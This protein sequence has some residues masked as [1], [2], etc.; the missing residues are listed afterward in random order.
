MNAKPPSKESGFFSKPCAN[1]K[2]TAMNSTEPLHSPESL[3]WGDQ[4][5]LGYAPIDEVHEEFVD[6][7]GQMQR[8][9][10][11]ALPALLAAFAAHLRRHFEMENEWMVTTEF[12]PRDCHMD[13]HAAVMASVEEVQVLLAQGEVAIC[14]DLVEQLAQWFPKHADQLDSALAH[15]MFSRT[16]GGKPVV[17][18]RGLSLR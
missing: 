5:L 10:D 1:F 12:P 14:R 13:E 7:I 3:H 15:W 17:L 8:G 2:A 6:L 9:P 11:A 4:F 18:R 16:M